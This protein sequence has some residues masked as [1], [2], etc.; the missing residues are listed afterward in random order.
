M[1]KVMIVE[2]LVYTFIVYYVG[3]WFG[4]KSGYNEALRNIIMK[5]KEEA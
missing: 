2:L 5:T 1:T 3:I 4:R